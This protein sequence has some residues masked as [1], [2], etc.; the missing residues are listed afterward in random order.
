[1]ASAYVLM[2]TVTPVVT[3]TVSFQTNDALTHIISPVTTTMSLTCSSHCQYH[4]NK[5]AKNHYANYTLCHYAA[6]TP[7]HKGACFIVFIS[8][9]K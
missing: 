8:H 5:M 1:M 9:T 3:Y 4:I 2:K 6:D 7:Q